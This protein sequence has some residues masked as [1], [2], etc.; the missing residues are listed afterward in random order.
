MPKSQIYN[1]YLIDLKS[2]ELSAPTRRGA[3]PIA[4]V[5]ALSSGHNS[6]ALKTPVVFTSQNI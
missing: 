3:T 5:Q 6:P 4:E 2:F 1:Q